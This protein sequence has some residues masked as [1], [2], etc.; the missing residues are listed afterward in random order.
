MPAPLGL[1]KMP[2]SYRFTPA[3][4]P[5]HITG[6]PTTTLATTTPLIQQFPTLGPVFD[7]PL[8][9]T[10]MISFNII[11]PA[12]EYVDNPDIDTSEQ[13][14]PMSRTRTLCD[15]PAVS[16]N[17]NYSLTLMDLPSDRFE[18]DFQPAPDNSHAR[19]FETAFCRD[20]SCCGLRLVDLHDLLQHYEECHVQFEDNVNDMFDDSEFFDED[21]WSDSDSPSPFP[22]SSPFDF[23][24]SSGAGSTPT[25]SAISSPSLTTA[26]ATNISRANQ[27]ALFLSLHGQPLR[28]ASPF[29]LYSHPSGNSTSDDLPHTF[30]NIQPSSLQAFSNFNAPSKRT[31]TDVYPEDDVEVETE[32]SDFYSED[33]AFSNTILRTRTNSSTS[34]SS[35][36]SIRSKRPSLRQAKRQALG[37]GRSSSSGSLPKT[38]SPVT[39]IAGSF[40]NMVGNKDSSGLDQTSLDILDLNH[41]LNMT[42]TIPG[43][44]GVDIRHDEVASLLEDIGKTNLSGDKPYRCRIS[45]C[46]KAYKNPNGLKYHNLHGHSS[47]TEETTESKPYVCTFLDCGR[48]YKNMNGLKYHVEH[49][50]PN[51]I[52]ALRAHHSGLTSNPYLFGPYSSHILTI[53]A[54]LAAVES[55]PMM[56]AATNAVVTHANDKAKE[57]ERT[58]TSRSRTRSITP[59]AAMTPGPGPGPEIG[60]LQK[61]L[62]DIQGSGLSPGLPSDLVHGPPVEDGSVSGGPGGD[63]VSTSG[64]LRF[65]H[66]SSS[67]SSG[68]R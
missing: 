22:A 11:N 37:L 31:S 19:E 64:P 45:G 18:N 54:A 55:S 63:L 7:I 56:M 9:F 5:V 1:Q 58:S 15:P 61:M 40:G 35:S 62:M 46:D 14:P 21:G 10:T 26:A 27:N 16:F 38:H 29:S 2:H 20:F 30:N 60:A 3:R 42:T 51:L 48:R 49:S 68:G 33:S 24:S 47:V 36:L 23:G 44:H 34:T 66:R 17:T 6:T 41:I 52:G 12:P 57:K 43:L 25:M 39:E 59:V 32:E 8:E 50:H 67:S 4:N 13:T 28:P 65:L 53:E